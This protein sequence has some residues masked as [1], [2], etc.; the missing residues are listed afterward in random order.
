MV[1][2]NATY[3]VAPAHP[4]PAGA[5]DVAAAARWV[6]LYIA[7]HGGDPQAVFLCG[8]S[9]GATHASTF[10]AMPRFHEPYGSGIKGLILISGNYDF[11]GDELPDRYRFY[12]GDDASKYE[13]RSPFKGLLANK[14][15]LMLA[16]AGLDP[17]SILAQSERLTAALKQAGRSARTVK[18]AHH[19]HISITY[20]ISTK[21]TELSDAM[22]EFIQGVG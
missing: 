21:D 1:G 7:R 3:R 13:E 14:V 19:S 22:L 6:R 9:A 18:L 10:V 8:H 5:E 4:W 11:T 2:V 12:L 20:S 15:P 16:W 17:P